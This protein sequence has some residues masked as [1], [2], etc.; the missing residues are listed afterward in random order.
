MSYPAGKLT[1]RGQQIEIFTNDDGSWLAFYGGARDR[2]TAETRDGLYKALMRATK[3]DATKVSVPFVQVGQPWSSSRIIVKRGTAT[4]LHSG[5]KNVLVT[6]SDGGKEQLDRYGSTAILDGDTDTN[7]W[8]R[9]FD[10]KQAAEIALSAFEAEHKL[11]LKEVVQAEL[12]K[13]MG[14]STGE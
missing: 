1:V 13:E 11:N 10:V 6:W 3:Q 5:N 2:I 4:G 9:L 14:G 8:R 7:E 12:D